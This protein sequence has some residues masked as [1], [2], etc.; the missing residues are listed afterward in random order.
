MLQKT[1]SWFMGN[2]TQGIV[3]VKVTSQKKAEV[4]KFLKAMEIFEKLNRKK[5]V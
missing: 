5:T 2:H 3:V 4:K 1:P